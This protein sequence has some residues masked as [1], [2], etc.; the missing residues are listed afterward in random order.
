MGIIE[1]HL[2]KNLISV[3]KQS[4]KYG[5]TQLEDLYLNLFLMYSTNLYILY[6]LKT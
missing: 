3:Y 6:I 4:W 2:L 1:C 5:F